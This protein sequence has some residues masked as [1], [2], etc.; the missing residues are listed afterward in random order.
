[1]LAVTGGSGR[2]LGQAKAVGQ[3]TGEQGNLG[4]KLR[5]HGVMN[6]GDGITEIQGMPAADQWY[7]P[8]AGQGNGTEWV[9]RIEVAAAMK[10][11]E[12]SRVRCQ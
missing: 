2:G 7:G 4:P 6:P 5:R 9:L 10:G 8:G 3:S 11:A 12:A 1:M